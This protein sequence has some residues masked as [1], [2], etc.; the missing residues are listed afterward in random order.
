MCN[1]QQQSPPQNTAWQGVYPG[2]SALNELFH[3]TSHCSERWTAIPMDWLPGFPWSAA[4]LRR[5]DSTATTSRPGDQGGGVGLLGGLAGDDRHGLQLP[6]DWRI[7]RHST[8]P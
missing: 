2:L 7:C 4:H 8:M 5:P 1:A 3:S 6:Q